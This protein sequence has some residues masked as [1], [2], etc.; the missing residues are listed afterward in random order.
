MIQSRLSGEVRPDSVINSK[1]TNIKPVSSDFEPKILG[2][3]CNWGA[4]SALEMAGVERYR[5]SSGV[6]FVRLM[7]IGRVHPG[8]ILKCFELGADGVMLLGCPSG[9]CHYEFGIDQTK[10]SMESIKKLLDI[11]GLGGKRL[12][13]V[14]VPA[15]D[16]KYLAQEI[17]RFTRRI[18]RMGANPANRGSVQSLFEQVPVG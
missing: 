8:L 16:G 14:E 7:C 15:G 5:Y 2:F 3:V 17:N 9:S 11:L 4:Y 1:M 12:R 10:Q 6:S 18:Q 13:L